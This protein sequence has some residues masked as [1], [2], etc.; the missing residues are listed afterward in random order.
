MVVK[1]S[2]DFRSGSVLAPSHLRKLAE[3]I[4]SNFSPDMIHE[5]SA[6]RLH[7]KK[8]PSDISLCFDLNADPRSMIY[9]VFFYTVNGLDTLIGKTIGMDKCKGYDDVATA[10]RS[11]RFHTQSNAANI[12]YS[13]LTSCK[14]FMHEDAYSVLYIAI[15]KLPTQFVLSYL[16]SSPESEWVLLKPSVGDIRSILRPEHLVNMGKLLSTFTS[17]NNTEEIVETSFRCCTTTTFVHVKVLTSKAAYH[18][19]FPPV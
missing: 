18:G 13:S 8:N 9:I 5:I 19:E 2:E 6:H 16:P 11:M 3:D 10:N 14:S 12:T 7:Q 15:L 17:S 4:T 1:R